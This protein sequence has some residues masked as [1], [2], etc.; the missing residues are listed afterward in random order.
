MIQL[1]P[2]PLQASGSQQGDGRR[3]RPFLGL[4]PLTDYPRCPP[5]LCTKLPHAEGLP[6]NPQVVAQ[7]FHSFLEPGC[8]VLSR[9]GR[10]L[11]PSPRVPLSAVTSV[12]PEAAKQVAF[13]VWE[14]AAPG[15]G[16][17]GRKKGA[18]PL[19]TSRSSFP[20]RPICSWGA[21]PS[22]RPASRQKASKAALGMKAGQASP[23]PHSK[24]RPG[25]GPGRGQS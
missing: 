10:V 12:P 20:L 6:L 23:D 7:H 1:S 25:P 17:K 22:G 2:T 9:S 13:V 11:P 14:Q 18:N 5:H 8:S 19:R 15:S 16:T 4:A 3:Y 21:Q 24:H